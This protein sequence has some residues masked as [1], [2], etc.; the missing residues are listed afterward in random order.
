MLL[1]RD[2]TKLGAF[3]RFDSGDISVA[4]NEHLSSGEHSLADVVIAIASFIVNN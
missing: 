1:T 3:E 2:D 4:I